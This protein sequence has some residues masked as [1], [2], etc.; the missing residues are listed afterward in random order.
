MY[1]IRRYIDFI[2]H[3][4]SNL[5]NEMLFC[6]TYTPLIKNVYD[7]HLLYTVCTVIPRDS[8]V[9]RYLIQTEL[10]ADYTPADVKNWCTCNI[11]NSIDVI[12]THKLTIYIVLV[13]QIQK[14][15]WRNSSW[16]KLSSINLLSFCLKWYGI[17]NFS[18]ECSWQCEVFK[19]TTFT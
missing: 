1:Y 18:M 7:C 5:L 16:D 11:I 3:Y 8:D 13:I 19:M 6:A 9:F 17:L 14:Q 4:Y 2:Q 12:L 10:I 15:D